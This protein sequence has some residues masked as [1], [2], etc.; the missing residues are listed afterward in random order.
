MLQSRPLH[1]AV[2]GE[3]AIQGLLL[4]GQTIRS[5]RSGAAASSRGR[6]CGPA[7]LVRSD[8]DL[9]HF[10]EGAV[11]MAKHSSPKFVLV[12][13][14]AAAPSSP[15]WEALPAIWPPW[16][17]NSAFPPFWA[18]EPQRPTSPHGMEMTV[19]AYEGRVYQGKVPELL[20]FQEPG[21]RLQG[22]AGVPGLEAERPTDRPPVS[23]RSRGPRIFP[24]SNAGP[25]MIS[26]DMCMKCPIPRCSRS[27]TWFPINRES[28][29]N[30]TPRFPLDFM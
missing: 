8:E 14:K 10:P 1:L 24:R 29:L 11:L 9:L 28:L 18:P 4:A 15:I 12:M 30:W 17:G 27:E 23:D 19:D 20:S 3:D 25:C 26:A 6:V 21:I 7:Y 5:D 2:A 13:K 16:P 22:Y